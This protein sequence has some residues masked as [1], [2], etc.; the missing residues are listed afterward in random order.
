M[1][2]Q[3]SKSLIIKL[4][5]SRSTIEWLLAIH[6]GAG[7]TVALI[8]VQGGLQWALWTALTL[9]GVVTLRAHGL[10][11]SARA[12]TALHFE[13]NGLCALR[14][15][16]DERWHEG[17]LCA[18]TVY[19]WLVVVSVRPAYRRRRENLII[20]ADAVAPAVFRQARLR[21][22]AWSAAV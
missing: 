21:L 5:I 20:P 17:T 19:P 15:G 6:I 14:Y 7:V 2:K 16:R 22:K 3:L 18:C 9:S 12:I 10:R 11:C 4:D 1:S 13:A 8:D